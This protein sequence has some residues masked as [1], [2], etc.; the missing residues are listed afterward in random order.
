MRNALPPNTMNTLASWQQQFLQGV[1]AQAAFLHVA[2]NAHEQ[3][4]TT[5]NLKKRLA[6]Y[7]GNYHL[8]LQSWLKKTYIQVFQL[9]GEDYFSKLAHD[10]SDQQP[11]SNNNLHE[12]GRG[13]PRFIAT[14]SVMQ[15]LPY[16]AD[17]A[18]VDWHISQAYYAKNKSS[19]DVA[20]FSQLCE[21]EQQSVTFILTD[22]LHIMSSN[23]PIYD[24]WR[25]NCGDISQVNILSVGQQI[26]TIY[27]K[28]YQAQVELTSYLE[29][30][31]YDSINSHYTFSE[32][33]EIDSNFSQ[34]ISQWIQAA[35][36]VDFS[37]KSRD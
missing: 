15:D 20:A 23:F 30:Q 1:Q 11:L 29:Q 6:A 24:I 14:Q 7:D 2:D 16:L 3:H 12:Y 28:S 18:E 36:I 26:V 37:K 33:L 27:R 35:W 32:L 4:S 13:F 5:F 8:S 22:D 17:V 31:L 10:F 19:F 25:L 21:T 9:V 34:L